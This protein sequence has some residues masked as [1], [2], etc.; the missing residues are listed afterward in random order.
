MALSGQVGRIYE[1]GYFW[2]EASESSTRSSSANR[3]SRRCATSGIGRS[4][5]WTRPKSSCSRWTWTGG[6]RWSTARAAPC[7][8]GRADELLGRDWIE[9]C[10]PARIRDAF[11]QKFHSWSA[12]I[13]PSSRTRSHQVGRGAADRMA[14]HGAARRRGQVIG[15][16]SSGT[17]ITERE[18]GSR[19]TAN[20]GRAHAV[21]AGGAR[22]SGSGT[23]TT[24]PGCSGGPRS[25]KPSTACSPAHLAGRSRRSS[26][27]SIPTIASAV[28]ETIAKARSRAPISRSSTD[29]S[30]PTARCGG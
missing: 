17:D 29:R 3:R 15:T 23:W 2:R 6:S 20:G 24:P 5:T 9:T 19:G 16:F 22:A 12:E 18:S 1:N 25:S 4:D 21:C 8:D 26:S 7:S 27:A 30:G 14:Q 28:L 13:C 11:R 10:L